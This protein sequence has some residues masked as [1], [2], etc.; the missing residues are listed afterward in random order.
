MKTNQKK[1]VIVTT[2]MIIVIL[3]SLVFAQIT[4]SNP[5]IVNTSCE[6]IDKSYTTKTPVIIY[7]DVY[8]EKNDTYH[9]EYTLEGYNWTYHEN[10]VL[11]CEEEIMH[12]GKY[13]NYRLQGY[14]C[15]KTDDNVVCDS[16]TDGNCDGKCSSN[17]GE[18]CCTF[19]NNQLKCKNSVTS[20][21]EHSHPTPVP[22]LK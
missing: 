8:D 11:K 2:F 20:W 21:T 16:C 7:E 9:R 4:P 17:G 12:K 13:I 6:W 19:I 22:E 10:I 3:M 18:T 1:L 14:N 5:K 15:T